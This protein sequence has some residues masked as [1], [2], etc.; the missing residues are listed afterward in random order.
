M[1]PREVGQVIVVADELTC[2]DAWNVQPGLES[3]MATD[4]P[5]QSRE[6][7]RSQ[8]CRWLF[9]RRS[10]TCRWESL[11]PP[12]PATGSAL[13]RSSGRCR[14]EIRRLLVHRRVDCQ[15]TH[16]L[17]PA[18]NPTRLRRIGCRLSHTGR[19]GPGRATSITVAATELPTKTC[20]R[21]P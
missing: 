14:L 12:L 1:G 20:H 19:L 21:V 6:T 15:T 5:H 16:G 11:E 4:P 13:P 8:S 9:W 17:H 18:G 3:S 10:E 2:S 7:R